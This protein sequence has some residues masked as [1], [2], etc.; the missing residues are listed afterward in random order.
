[1]GTLMSREVS[2]GLDYFCHIDLKSQKSDLTHEVS[3]QPTTG[4]KKPS[5]ADF[6]S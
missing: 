6:D 5:S 4:K 2:K 3:L 1:M